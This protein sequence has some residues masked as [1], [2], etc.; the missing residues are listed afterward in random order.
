MRE[1]VPWAAGTS[2]DNVYSGLLVHL[3]RLAGGDAPAVMPLLTDV[4]VGAAA[5]SSTDAPAVS[6]SLTAAIVSPVAG[7]EGSEH[8]PCDDPALSSLD[9]SAAFLRRW[10]RVAMPLLLHPA[11]ARQPS[12]KA[13]Y[14]TAR[15]NFVLAASIAAGRDLCPYFQSELRWPVGDGIASRQ[16][17]ASRGL[18]A[19][20]VALAGAVAPWP[21]VRLP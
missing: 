4:P 7:P 21:A 10:F 5:A 6:A 16:G 9:C 14:A 1:L 17:G 13:D 12:S 2:L 11:L 19:D 18:A 20:L 15:D 3:C 8:F